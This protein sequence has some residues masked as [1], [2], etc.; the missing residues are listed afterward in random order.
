MPQQG[1]VIFFYNYVDYPKANVLRHVGLVL[2]VENGYVF[3]IEGNTLTNRLDYLYYEEVLPL[4]NID[5]QPND[6]VAV[7]HYLLND[8]QIHGYAVP[9]YSNRSAFGHNG[10]VDLG[11]YEPLRKI[12]VFCKN[13]FKWGNCGLVNTNSW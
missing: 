4:R 1:D 2:C 12:F 3:T 6:Y 7:K 9:N 13:P 11:K 5:F 8:P 10:W